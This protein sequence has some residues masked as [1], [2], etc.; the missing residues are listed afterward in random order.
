[1][2]FDECGDNCA[3]AQLP[4]TEYAVFWRPF[5]NPLVSPYLGGTILACPGQLGLMDDFFRGRGGEGGAPRFLWTTY[6]DVPH[7]FDVRDGVTR[8]VGT[9]SLN[10]AEGDGVYLGDAL[11]VVVWVE[12]WHYGAQ[13]FKRVYLMRDR[14]SNPPSPT[15]TPLCSAAQ[16]CNRAATVTAHFSNGTG[17]ATCLNGVSAVL[18]DSLASDS[19]PLM[20]FDYQSSGDSAGTCAPVSGTCFAQAEVGAS[21]TPNAQFFYFSPAGA[22]Q[23]LISS[24]THPPTSIAYNCAGPTMTIRG[25]PV[26][27]N[28]ALLG[29]IDIDI[30]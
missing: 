28:G 19:F 22:N 3:A 26:Y 24:V 29:N 20:T 7:T 5:G 15:L 6:V 25:Q 21:L 9:N 10:Y 1:M 14:Y 17:T 8:T 27:L 11:Y 2:S 30:A 4:A 23:L 12:R 16:I 13:H 18:A